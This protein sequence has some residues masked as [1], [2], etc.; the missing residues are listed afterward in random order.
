MEQT[1]PKEP[2]IAKEDFKEEDLP[3]MVW[4]LDTKPRPCFGTKE[5]NPTRKYRGNLGTGTEI[6]KRVIAILKTLKDVE[7]P[8]NNGAMTYSNKNWMNSKDGFHIKYAR[9][10]DVFLE[11][12]WPKYCKE[13]K[14]ELKNPEKQPTM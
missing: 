13:K 11:S 8:L 4:Y 7:I 2:T 5:E 6:Q 14:S 10:P 12:F 9:R 1:I 3:F